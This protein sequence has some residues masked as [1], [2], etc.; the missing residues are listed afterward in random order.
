LLRAEPDQPDVFVATELQ[1]AAEPSQLEARDL[2]GD[3]QLE[4][5]VL[6][7]SGE[8]VL[9]FVRDGA[10]G[11]GFSPPIELETG[12]APE[13]FG[14]VDLDADG[15]L[16]LVIADD[17][18]L[19]AR[20]Q[21]PGLSF[22][23]SVSIAAASAGPLLTLDLDGDGQRELVL[24]EP[25]LSALLSVDVDGAGGLVGQE[26]LATAAATAVSLAVDLDGEGRVDL[27]Q[28]ELGGLATLRLHAPVDAAQFG[29]SST[30]AVG[31]PS[32]LVVADLDAD[33]ALDLIFSSSLAGRVTLFFQDPVSP[34]SFPRSLT[35][36][37][38]SRAGA[39]LVAELDGDGRPDI[40]VAEPDRA[41]LRLFLQSSALRGDFGP[42]VSLGV[43]AGPAAVISGDLD[44]DGR[45]D[46]VVACEG[47]GRLD[48]L[49]Q[50]AGG[51]GVF[52]TLESVALSSSTASPVGLLRLPR[53]GEL[54]VV[55][56]GARQVELLR[57]DPSVVGGLTRAAQLDLDVV[58]T[59]VHAL[60]LD[61]QG[62]DELLVVSS[63]QLTLVDVDPSLSMLILDRFVSPAAAGSASLADL[64][65]DGLLDLV[66]GSAAAPDLGLLFG[67]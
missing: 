27:V 33:G 32:D 60:Q 13:G 23:A 18:G 41:S 11:L 26:S 44:G 61:G 15:R 43:G 4:L 19:S 45:P 5:T 20:L 62:R 29:S 24:A 53:S 10:P 9:V 30:L 54:A 17:S 12:A 31:D 22:G 67:R 63:T 49:R 1:T 58:P 66:L 38:P 16:D 6:C 52:S 65:G 3:G 7:R 51:A 2:D 56:A 46:L 21:G 40:V 35:L 14:F 42:S 36:T 34:G 39:L 8:R 64:D 50:D 57:L 28:G 47:D 37:T 55:C 25:A 48:V 59:A